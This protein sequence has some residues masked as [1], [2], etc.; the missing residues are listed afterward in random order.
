MN[1]D[2][3]KPKV[4]TSIVKSFDPSGVIQAGA[5]VVNDK[6]HNL[7]VSTLPAHPRDDAKQS[8]RT[9]V[10]EQKK[11]K[12]QKEEKAARLPQ[13]ELRD[14]IFRCYDKYSYWSLKAFKQA[15]NQPE[16]WLRENLEDL[17]M[18]H[19]SGRF[20]NYWELKPEYKR[21]NVQVIEGAPPSP[22]ANDSD[23]DGD[24][25]NIEMEDVKPEG[26]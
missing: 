14:Q 18:L 7:V 25:D 17:A 9:A 21:V 13:S 2:A 6:F 19:K 12:K 20:A 22:E 1:D 24:D 3:M 5:H 8:Q 10:P 26:V 11:N 16:A 15:L 23:F 4:S